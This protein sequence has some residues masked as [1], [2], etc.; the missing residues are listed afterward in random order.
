MNRSTDSS[1]V[2]ARAIVWLAGRAL[3]AVPVIGPVI[4]VVNFVNDV[5]ELKKATAEA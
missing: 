2:I 4:K 5:A 1:V 3:E